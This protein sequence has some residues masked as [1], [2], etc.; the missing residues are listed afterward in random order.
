[1]PLVFSLKLKGKTKNQKKNERPI[2]S[3]LAFLKTRGAKATPE[4]RI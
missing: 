4:E 2:T 3:Y 1:L